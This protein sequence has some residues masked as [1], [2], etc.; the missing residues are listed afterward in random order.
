[1]PHPDQ[2]SDPSST[3]GTPTRT[4]QMSDDTQ[5]DRTIGVS[6]I[7]A[8]HAMAILRERGLIASIHGRRNVRSARLRKRLSAQSRSGRV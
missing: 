7:T 4:A 2:P 5:I 1:M 6:Y 8:Q 3:A